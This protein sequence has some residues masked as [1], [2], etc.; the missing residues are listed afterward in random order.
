MFHILIVDNYDSFTFNLR[1]YLEKLDCHVDVIKNDDNIPP[2]SEY[3]ALIISPGPGLPTEAGHLMNILQDAVGKI[4]ILGVCLGMQALAIH[5]GG[6]IYNQMKVK[7]GVSE[8]I[9]T[10]PGILFRVAEDRKVGL[11]HSWAVLEK[12]DFKI[13]AR[14]LNENVVMAIENK[15]LMCFGVQFHPESILSDN[16]IEI[17]ENF[18]NFC[19]KIKG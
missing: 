13:I 12:G 14:S 15:D 19:S 18:L 9:V 17:L 4:P 2:L 1:H 11:Y 5:L 8:E 10:E 3:N 7:H 16:G 6:G